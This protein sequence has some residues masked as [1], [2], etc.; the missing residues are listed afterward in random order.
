MKNHRLFLCFVFGLLFTFF[1]AATDSANQVSAQTPPAE[2][3]LMFYMDSDNNLEAPQMEDL[4]EMMAVG[5]SAN[6]NLIGLVDRS[7]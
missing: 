2:W 5:S 7:S 6:I 4:E 3:T 1:V